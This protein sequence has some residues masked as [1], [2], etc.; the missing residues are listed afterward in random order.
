MSVDRHFTRELNMTVR[1]DGRLRLGEVS[2]Y[3]S[4]IVSVQRGISR[5]NYMYGTLPDAE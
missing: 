5:H 4:A 3:I 1:N 2:R